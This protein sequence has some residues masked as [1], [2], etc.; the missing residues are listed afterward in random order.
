MRKVYIQFIAAIFC[1]TVMLNVLPSCNNKAESKYEKVE[2]EEEEEN[3]AYD[4]DR[5]SVV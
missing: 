3:E 4:R 2:G 1:A 5:K